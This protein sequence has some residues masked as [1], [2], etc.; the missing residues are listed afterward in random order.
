M[1]VWTSGLYRLVAVDG[2]DVHQ[3]TMR[4]SWSISQRM[5]SKTAASGSKAGG[6][7]SWSG[8]ATTRI[9]S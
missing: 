9:S 8:C 1:K 3:P 7:A 2:T 4:G 5:P 6:W